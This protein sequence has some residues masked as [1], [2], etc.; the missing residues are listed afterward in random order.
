MGQHDLPHRS[1]IANG[2]LSH[3]V[4]ATRLNLTTDH[5][6]TTTQPT[7]AQGSQN[8]V[9]SN[10]AAQAA[11]PNTDP[12]DIAEAVMPDLVFGDLAPVDEQWV[13]EHTVI[14]NSCANVLHTLE[15]VCSALDECADDYCERA[16]ERRPSATA[17]LGLMEA[18]YG[19]LDTPVGDVLVAASARG[20]VEISYL[21]HTSPY[22][23]LRELEGRG[24]LVYERQGTVEPIVDQLREYFAHERIRFDLPVDLGGVTPFTRSV[25]EHTVHI[26]YGKVQTYGD[27]ASAIGKPKASRAVGNALGRNPVPVIIP[28]HRVI[29]SSGA[30][31]WYTGGPEIKRTLLGIEGVSYA[32]REQAAQA[33]LGIE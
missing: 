7:S 16:A 17:C 1:T 28:C 12:C 24:Y 29:L 13:R 31:G 6:M 19:F 27:V 26:P 9:P 8:P 23:S 21:N 20:V 11:D 4:P 18:R 3:P 30:M 5:S 22:E 32:A 14:C 2:H 33:S 10:L 25:L 15:D